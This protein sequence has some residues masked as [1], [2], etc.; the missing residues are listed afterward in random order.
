MSAS[1]SS[2]RLPAVGIAY[3]AYVP[4]LLDRYPDSIDYVEVPYELLRHDPRVI[5]VGWRTPI[6]LHCASLSIGG[7]IPCPE[8]TIHEIKDWV[9]RTNTPW[10]GEHLAYITASRSEA[11]T[12]PQPYAPD[13][14][15]NIG[16]TVSP[17]MNEVTLERTIR[18]LNSYEQLFDVRLLVENSPLYFRMPTT[19]MS[20]SE[21]IQG[22]CSQTSVGLLLD[23]A[24]LYITS[25]TMGFDPLDELERLPLE[26]V[27]EV[28]ISGV[29]AQ[30]GGFWDD[31]ARPAPG[32]LYQML[33]RVAQSAMPQ[34]VTL[35]YN[36][37]TSFP[38]TTLLK[39]LETV[40]ETL[41]R[42]HGL[43]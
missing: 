24:H 18:N 32:I 38:A 2:P 29:D 35:E 9:D 36:W 12:N 27:V 42:V 33:A 15:Y 43:G 37:S 13:E 25:L 20:Q 39:E 14:P 10:V 8:Q 6:V 34:A 22:L 31:H 3:S 7:T 4:T 16:Y 40:R 1:T 5:E 28:H 30:L 21:F 41:G 19:T 17:P 26:R 11:G 23:L